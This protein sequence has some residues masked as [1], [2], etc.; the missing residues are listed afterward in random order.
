M[1]FIFQVLSAFS[2]EGNAI[3]HHLLHLVWECVELIPELYSLCFGVFVVCSCCEPYRDQWE[4]NDLA[5]VG[6][7]WG[8]TWL[9]PC[10]NENTALCFS[11]KSG[12]NI[13]DNVESLNTLSSCFPE[14]LE[15]I[16][17]FSRLWNTEQSSILRREIL[18]LD[19]WCNFDIYHWKAPKLSH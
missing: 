13:V 9:L 10:I 8:D 17:S 18:V 2:C 7:S 19:L 5:K 4:S 11:C 15:E 12:F 16:C 1:S 6:F 14:R 3:L